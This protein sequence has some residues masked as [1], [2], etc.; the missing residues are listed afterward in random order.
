M[1]GGEVLDGK[2]GLLEEV[3]V[4]GRL[5]SPLL[6]K[7]KKKD[8]NVRTDYDGNYDNNEDDDDDNNYDD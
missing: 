4:V 6:M 2:E 1:E 7:E 8:K 3:V 5:L